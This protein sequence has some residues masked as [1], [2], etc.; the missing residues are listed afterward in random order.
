MNKRTLFPVA[1]F[2]AVC[3]R[4][5]N[6]IQRDQRFCTRCGAFRSAMPEA[7][8]GRSDTYSQ[9]ANVRQSQLPGRDL[10]DVNADNARAHDLS[11]LPSRPPSLLQRTL[12]VRAALLGA[13]AAAAIACG[14]TYLRYAPPVAVR[15]EEQPA[16]HRD[17]GAEQNL[18][19]ET[20]YM[21]PQ[22]LR[23]IDA[24]LGMSKDKSDAV[25]PS[26]VKSTDAALSPAQVLIDK[27]LSVGESPTDNRSV[28]DPPAM[29]VVRP[30]PVTDTDFSQPQQ[31]PTLS[32]DFSNIRDPEA[33]ERAIKEY[34]WTGNTGAATQRGSEN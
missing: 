7:N 19:A 24:T 23:Q 4:C 11:T 31:R 34:G 32:R 5:G 6:L 30:A 14:L 15:D 12:S 27:D 28:V 17:T 26:D 21:T 22:A 33:L 8:S 16:R 9:R 10:V 13:C 1:M 25:P 3:P 2:S 29:A 18:S 20:A